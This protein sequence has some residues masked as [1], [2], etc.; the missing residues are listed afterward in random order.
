MNEVDRK[1][2]I[3]ARL[4]DAPKFLWWDFDVAMLFMGSVVLGHPHVSDPDVFRARSRPCLQLSK[5]EGRTKPSIRIARLVLAS[6]DYLRTESDPAIGFARIHWLTA[7]LR[8]R[9]HAA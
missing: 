9:D 7:L 5:G 8:Q 1:Y 3:P 4:D 6:P 2:I